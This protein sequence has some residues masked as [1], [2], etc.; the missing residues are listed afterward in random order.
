MSSGTPRKEH[1]QV[2]IQV[3]S[4]ARDEFSAVFFDGAKVGNL[5][6]RHNP[7]TG[8]YLDPRTGDSEA[9]WAAVAGFG[10]VVS[11]TVVHGKNAEGLPGRVTLGIVELDEGPWWWCQLAG[12]NP[13]ADLMGLRVSAEFVPSGPNPEH[14]TI[15][16]FVPSVSASDR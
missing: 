3:K 6:L 9:E 5:L 15:P 11:W 8:D 7:R 4:V 14:E 16:V 1:C 13:D 10:T 12:V 2:N